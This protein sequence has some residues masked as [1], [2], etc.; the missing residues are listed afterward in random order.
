MSEN[1]N[2]LDKAAIDAEYRRYKSEGVSETIPLRD[3]ILKA[4]EQDSPQ[5]WASLQSQGLT[6]KLAFVVQERMWRRQD[7][8]MK[9]GYPVTDARETAERE[10]LM[11]EPE[12]EP[13]T[14]ETPEAVG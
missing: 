13:T 10:E 11:L 4:W 8:L 2:L 9:V 6:E 7:E 5:M 3:R 1:P 12:S 14:D